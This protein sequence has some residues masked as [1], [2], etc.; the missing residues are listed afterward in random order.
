M[1]VG[2][3]VQEPRQQQ[4]N[5]TH[6]SHYTQT[7]N[8]GG[9]HQYTTKTDPQTN[10]QTDTQIRDSCE[11]GHEETANVNTNAGGG[12]EERMNK[13]EAGREPVHN[14]I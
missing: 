14:K 2:K 8:T 6:N 1:E 13:H 7:H 9:G 10:R 11:V 5:G 4:E 12:V 3:V